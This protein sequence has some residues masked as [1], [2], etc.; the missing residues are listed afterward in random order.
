MRRREF[1]L[2]GATTVACG[3]QLL[4]TEMLGRRLYWPTCEWTGPTPPAHSIIPV[5]G[6]GKWVWNDPPADQTGYLE[7][8]QYELSIGIQLGGDGP[9]T[10]I[11]ATTTVPVELPEQKID[12]VSIETSG[13][14][15]GIRRLS[16]HAAQLY[17]AAP[18]IRAGQ[19]IAAIARYRLTLSK[20]YFGFG[21]EQFPR[22]QEV[23]KEMAREYLRTSPGIQSNVREVRDMAESLSGQ[24]DHPW[25][26]AAAFHDWVRENI[27]TRQGAFTSVTRALRDRVGD[28]EERAA[29]FV[30]FCR[31]VG[32]PARL[33]WVPNHNWAEFC[34]L[35]EAGQPHWIPAHTSAY[36][37]FGWTGA[38]ELV[39]QKGDN[40][41]VPEKR[42]T[43]RLVPDWMQWQGTRPIARYLGQ[44]RPLPESEGGE[45]GPGARCK[46]PTGEWRVVRLDPLDTQLRDGSRALT[47]D[48]IASLR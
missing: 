33:V 39:L 45:A 31:S 4:S 30:A 43:V 15:A 17:L 9:A 14:E 11:Q 42:K 32:I 46:V 2:W 19:V 28:C 18:L 21:R 26:Q 1:L 20:S 10:A 38:H 47:A 5:V 36:S 40:V 12:D 27:D 48:E 24:I 22:E 35:D 37:W 34:L 44:L 16:E 29:V 23:P 25:D 13:C 8:R 41:E 6:D 3:A 7:P